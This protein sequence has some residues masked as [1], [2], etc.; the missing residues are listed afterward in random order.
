MSILVNKVKDSSTPLPRFCTS[1]RTDDDLVCLTPQVCL[2]CWAAA[3]KQC[4][5]L[6]EESILSICLTDM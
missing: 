4:W 3:S 6:Y 5:F 2:E 1:P